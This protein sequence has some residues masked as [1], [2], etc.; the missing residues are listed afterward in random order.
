MVDFNL[1]SDLDVLSGEIDSEMDELFGEGGA[2]TAVEELMK[3]DDEQYR[4]GSILTGKVV[5]YAG[6]DIVVDVGLKSEGIVPANEWDDK[7]SVEIGDE[8]QVWLEAIESDRGHIVL[9]KRKADRLLN[10]QRIVEKKEEGDVVTGTVMR[11]IKGGLL[12]DIGYPVFLPASQ[13]DIRRPG[14]L[15][16]LIGKEIEAKLLKIAIETCYLR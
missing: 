6:D 13:V 5:A 12:V 14:D 3:T 16:L 15:G 10:W 4:P 11:K 8:V 2:S 1:I 9:S 7:N